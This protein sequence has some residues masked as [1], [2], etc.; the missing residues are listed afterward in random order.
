VSRA[1]RSPLSRCVAVLGI[2]RRLRAPCG[3]HLL[4][5]ALDLLG[6][7]VVERRSDNHDERQDLYLGDRR[8]HRRAANVKIKLELQPQG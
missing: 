8:R 4:T 6:E 2:V 1:P 7:E 5:L 3:L